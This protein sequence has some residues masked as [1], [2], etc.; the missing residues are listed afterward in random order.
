MKEALRVVLES[1][2]P[3]VP[4]VA[5][6]L[7]VLL[8]S[9]VSCDGGGDG[10]SDGVGPCCHVARASRADF[11]KMDAKFTQFIGS[12]GNPP[13]PWDIQCAFVNE[14]IP[15]VR[16]VADTCPWVKSKPA[17]GAC[18]QPDYAGRID[19]LREAAGYQIAAGRSCLRPSITFG[20]YEISVDVM[21]SP[22]RS[23]IF[24]LGVLTLC[25]SSIISARVYWPAKPKANPTETRKADEQ[26]LS[27]K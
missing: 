9:L 20:T 1:L 6:L 5:A 13:F 4:L 24:A 23:I 8:L 18:I 14:F 22:W 16:G 21:M 25:T 3:L 12:Y 11:E 19:A 15:L 2:K 10:R 17:S 27:T 26:V 7:G